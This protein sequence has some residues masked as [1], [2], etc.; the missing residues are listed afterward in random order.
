MKK[1]FCV[2]LCAVIVSSFTACSNNTDSKNS[3]SQSSNLSVD[4]TNLKED[5]YDLSFTDRDCDFSYDK[6]GACNVTFSET[7]AKASSNSASVNKGEVTIGK[8]GTYILSGKCT[9]GSVIVDAGDNDKIQIVLNGL[10]LTSSKSPF[11]IKNADKVFITLADNSENTLSDASSYE[12]TVD[13]STVDGAIFSKADLTIN[14]NGKL[15]VNGN[16]KHAVVSKDDLVIAGG[17]LNVKSKSS[18]IDGKDCVKIKDADITVNSGSDAIRSTNT[19]ETD[20]RGFVY[21][22]SGTFK[23]ES[24]NDAVQ[25]VSL[26]RIDGGD[27]NITTGGGSANGETHPDSY[28]KGMDWYSSSSDS[29]DTES[30]KAIKS[31][32]TIEINGG[33]L[34][35]DS[36]DDAIHSNNTVKITNG[37]LEINAGDDGIHADNALTID[38][39]TINIAQSYEGIE[40]GKIT[41][42]DGNINLVSND[43]GFNCAGGSDGDIEQGSFS[44]D[45]SKTLT[46]NGGYV[47]VDSTGDGLDSNGTIE[48]KGGTVL[49]SGPENNGNGAIDYEKSATITG[50]V[51]IAL[52]S[53]GMSQSITGDGQCSIMTNISTQS[54]GTQFALCDS[55][56]NVLASFKSSKSYTNAV[57][58]SPLINTGETYSI[59]CGGS[60]SDA[61]SNGFAQSGKIS[62]GSSVAEITMTD[63][64]YSEGGGFGGGGHGGKNRMY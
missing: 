24:T 25:A 42:N 50:G 7:S 17:T 38:G 36:S 56:G 46:I 16:Y 5:N 35:I 49:V 53:S 32:D 4:V 47:L 13:D 29:T 43:D 39:G 55:N 12:L 64:N 19:D 2:L 54:G 48:I 21:I 41:V 40:A 45:S 14:G 28:G 3:E 20:S 57:V 31:A 23:L 33:K 22:N 30:A 37:E 26:L 58:S 44:S 11:I 52:G 60:L 59:V 1:L 34:S 10:D 62:G 8:E 51:L 27:F 15:T 6:K 63:E 9:D 61:D 18:G